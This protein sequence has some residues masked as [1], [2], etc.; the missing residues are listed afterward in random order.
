MTDKK[1]IGTT[2]SQS[3]SVRKFTATFG[4][5]FSHIEHDYHL[6]QQEM[7]LLETI[8]RTIP[9][10]T[11]QEAEAFKLL[12]RIERGIALLKT[13]M[14]ESFWL[15]FSARFNAA[16]ESDDENFKRAAEVLDFIW[17]LQYWHKSGMLGSVLHI[18]HLQAK[19]ALSL[20]PERGNVNWGAVNAVDVLRFFWWRNMGQDGPSRALN[21]SS[22]FAEY[23]CA[24]F[25]YLKVKGKPLPAFKAWAKHGKKFSIGHL[26]LPSLRCQD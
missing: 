15:P 5:F 1:R 25:R 16:G 9:M 22:V 2:V 10:Q 8:W 26:G 19:A 23:L 18:Y 11:V 14:D 21:P 7:E 6:A 4:K 17:K 12:A 13:P 3:K 24:G 20:F